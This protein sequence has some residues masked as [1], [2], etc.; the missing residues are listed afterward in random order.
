M[1]VDARLDGVR[2]DRQRGGRLPNFIVIGAMKA[3]TTSL[4]HYLQVHPQAYLSPLKEVD[5]F[6]EEKNWQ[7]GLDWYRAQFDGAGPEIRAV[8]EASTLY[9][10]FPEYQGVPERMA[11]WIPEARLIY[12]VRN[13]IERIR[14]HYQHRVLAGSERLPLEEAVLQDRRYL[15]C[16]RYAMQ[17]ERYLERFPREQILLETSEQLRSNRL[18]TMRRIYTFLGIDPDFV[19][20]TIDR[21]FYASDERASY[22]RIAWWARR[23]LKRYLPASKRAKEMIDLALP[24]ILGRRA[25]SSGGAAPPRFEIP[26][27]VRV[28]LVER[29]RDDI[30]RFRT[31]MPSDFDG[32]GIV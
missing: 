4:F 26:E 13:P 28:E 16:S 2:P 18:S 14:S 5:F 6:V 9:T 17:I 22:P 29:L 20:E 15:D 21:E 30:A 23:T 8:G 1:S 24:T 32:W 12:V 10:K 11:R 25:R 7:R 27:A 19:H 31:Y 3:G